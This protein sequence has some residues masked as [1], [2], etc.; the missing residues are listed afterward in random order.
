MATYSSILAWRIPWTE[1]PGGLQPM[2]SQRVGHDWAANTLI[3]SEIQYHCDYFGCT[4]KMKRQKTTYA[5]NFRK[6][7]HCTKMQ[8]KKE[9]Q[10]VPSGCNGKMM[11]GF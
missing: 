1:E 3:E 9:A 8:R 5:H 2:G 10:K 6:T 11:D 4:F 7:V